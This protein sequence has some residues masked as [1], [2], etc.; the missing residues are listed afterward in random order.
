MFPLNR[1]NGRVNYTAWLSATIEPSKTATEHALREAFHYFDVDND[2]FVSEHDLKE[3]L[4]ADDP[5]VQQL[6][7]DGDGRL[8]EASFQKRLLDVVNNIES[9]PALGRARTTTAPT[10]NYDDAESTLPRSRRGF[11]SF[12]VKAS[13]TA[14]PTI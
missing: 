12:A 2:G 6:F 8:D 10:I 3:I 14:A 13:R 4:G 5:C 1:E 9:T 7:E 11:S